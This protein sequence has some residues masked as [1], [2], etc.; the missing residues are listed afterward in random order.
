MGVSIE[1]YRSRIGLYNNFAQA[2]KFVSKLKD[3]FWNQMLIMF[4]LKVFYLP[5]LKNLVIK[6]EKDNEV[7]MWYAQMICYHVYVPLLLRLSNDVEENPGP[8]NIN[9]IVDPTYTVHADMNPCLDPMLV[10]NVLPCQYAQLFT[11]KLN[12]LTFGTQPL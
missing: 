5:C 4:Y 12:Q 9:E 6:A 7:C 8:I 1:I 11:M 3:K 2:K 10:N